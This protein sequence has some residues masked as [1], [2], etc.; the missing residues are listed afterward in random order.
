MTETTTTVADDGDDDR[1]PEMSRDR[2]MGRSKEEWRTKFDLGQGKHRLAFRYFVAIDL[3]NGKKLES[4][5][6]LIRYC[7]VP[8]VSYTDYQLIDFSDDG[9]VSLL[10]EN[11]NTKDDL[12]LPTN[13]RLLSQ[14][15]DVFAEGKDLY[16]TVMSAM[17]EEQICAIV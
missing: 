3:F 17:G 13:D 1:S 10:T 11:C 15:K 16:V 5:V 8:Y 4:I 7:Q 2:E 6:P 14:I 12:R 9:F